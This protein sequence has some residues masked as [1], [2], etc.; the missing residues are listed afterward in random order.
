MYAEASKAAVTVQG[1]DKAVTMLLI[2]SSYEQEDMVGELDK[3]CPGWLSTCCCGRWV[4][5]AD[6]DLR[7]RRH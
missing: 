7:Q 6:L 4:Q 2:A 5:M 1:Q 3:F